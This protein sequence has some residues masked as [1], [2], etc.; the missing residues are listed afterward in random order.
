MGL[1]ACCILQNGKY[2][3]SE[4]IAVAAK[5]DAVLSEFFRLINHYK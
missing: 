1:A 2:N 3:I 5:A 4:I